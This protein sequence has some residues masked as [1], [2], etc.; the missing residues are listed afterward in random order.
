[1]QL[2]KIRCTGNK[3]ILSAWQATVDKSFEVRRVFFWV[4]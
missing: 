2:N 4:F 3:T 1:M